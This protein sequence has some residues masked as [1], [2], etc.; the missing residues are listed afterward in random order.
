MML[1]NKIGRMPSSSEICSYLEIDSNLYAEVISLTS[2]MM[3]LDDEYQTLN[4]DCLPIRECVGESRDYITNMVVSDSIDSLDDL[5]QQ[6]IK[7]RYFEDL[8]QMET[9]EV[10]GIS[11]VKSIKNRKIKSKKKIKRVYSCIIC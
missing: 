7:I 6:V 9:A 5:E 4:G 10:L 3:S 2:K 1:A 8:T 11:Q